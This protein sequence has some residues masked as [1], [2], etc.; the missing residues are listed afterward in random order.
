[1]SQNVTQMS[2]ELGRFIFSE[3]SLVGYSACH[4]DR[5]QKSEQFL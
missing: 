3:R 4:S 2:K 1:M 5:F